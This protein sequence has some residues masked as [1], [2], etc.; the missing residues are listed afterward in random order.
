MYESYA[1]RKKCPYRSYS[2]PNF[3]RIFRSNKQTDIVRK[4]KVTGFKEC[5]RTK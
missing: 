4:E 1:L 2:G 3:S 5:Q